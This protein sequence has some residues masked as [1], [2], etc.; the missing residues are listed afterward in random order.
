MKHA[1]DNEVISLPEIKGM[2]H[3]RN[4]SCSNQHHWNTLH[5]ALE[6]S[7]L[8][9]SRLCYLVGDTTSTSLSATNTEKGQHQEAGQN[10]FESLELHFV[11][12]RIK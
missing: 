4:I 10:V 9:Y 2:Y 3:L 7:R 6:H 11:E 5:Q 12:L 1:H 8:D